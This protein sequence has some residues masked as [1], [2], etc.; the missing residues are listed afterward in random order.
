M[1]ESEHP[2]IQRQVCLLNGLMQN[3]PGAPSLDCILILLAWCGE[4]HVGACEC[5]DACPAAGTNACKCSGESS[6]FDPD[7]LILRI[8]L[9]EALNPALEAAGG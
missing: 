1:S 6:S 9:E 5:H 4:L 2:D 3:L 7:C 8:R